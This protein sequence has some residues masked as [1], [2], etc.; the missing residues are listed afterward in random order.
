MWNLN[1]TLAK[2]HWTLTEVPHTILWSKAMSTQ[3]LRNMRQLYFLNNP[4][5]L[6]WWNFAPPL[7]FLEVLSGN[8]PWILSGTNCRF[9]TEYLCFFTQG[10]KHHDNG[11]ND[12]ASHEGCLWTCYQECSGGRGWFSSHQSPGRYYNNILKFNRVMRLKL[13]PFPSWEWMV[14]QLSNCTGVTRPRYKCGKHSC[15]KILHISSGSKCAK[16]GD[17]EDTTKLTTL[18]S[19]RS[20]TPCSWSRSIS[21]ASQWSAAK[22][23]L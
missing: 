10:I 22:G 18:P 23:H 17:H 5:V 15:P 2:V 3:K 1:G 7:Q 21:L 19:S 11:H 4:L 20:F 13:K 9:C 12:P 16:L 6:L 14:L 8:K